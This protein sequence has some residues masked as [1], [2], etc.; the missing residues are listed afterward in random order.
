M[1]VV[2]RGA[3]QQRDRGVHVGD[4]DVV[5]TVA[6]PVEP[7]HAA[8]QDVPVEE[9]AHAVGFQFHEAAASGV[10]QVLGRHFIERAVVGKVFDVS[11]GYDQVEFSIEVGVDEL[12]APAQ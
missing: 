7:C 5:E 1:A 9:L 11:V 8:A 3:G 4:Q 10:V 2:G 12:C 6:I